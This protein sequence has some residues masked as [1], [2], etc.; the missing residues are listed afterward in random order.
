MESQKMLKAIIVA[1]AVLSFGAA[2]IQEASAESPAAGQKTTVDKTSDRTPGDPSPDRTEGADRNGAVGANGGQ[3]TGGT[4]DRTPAH[5]A[6][7]TDAARAPSG[8]L[9]T[10]KQ[11]RNHLARLGYTNISELTKDESGAWRGSAK[12]DGKSVMVGI[13]VKGTVA[14]N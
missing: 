9:F 6:E 2:G 12:K 14:T 5:S 8:N 1:A 4:S 7:A 3:T 13:D 11:A 10:E